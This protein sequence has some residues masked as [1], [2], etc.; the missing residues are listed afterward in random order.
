MHLTQP[1]PDIRSFN[2]AFP[3]NLADVLQRALAKDPAKRYAS[4]GEFINILDQVVTQ[5]GQEQ[6]RVLYQNAREQ[7]RLLKFD[8]AIASL[9]QVLAIRSSTEVETLLQECQ[10][11]KV[12]CDEVQNLREQLSH[13]QTRLN[14]ILSTEQWLS[15]LAPNSTKGKG[16]FGKR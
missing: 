9:N 7:M 16:L 4:A 15:T 5:M 12:I 11:R 2:Q 13:S 8:A 14:Q 10:R 6:M 1:P 3:K